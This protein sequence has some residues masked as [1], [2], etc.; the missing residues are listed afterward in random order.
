[1]RLPA[2]CFSPDPR[3]HLGRQHLSDGRLRVTQQKAGTSLSIPVHPELKKK[4][5]DAAEVGTLNFLNTSQGVTLYGRR[6]RQLFPRGLQR[7]GPPE[8]AAV[9]DRLFR[10]CHIDRDTQRWYDNV[11]CRYEASVSGQDKVHMQGLCPLVRLAERRCR[12]M[13]HEVA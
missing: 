2:H 1:M 13:L 4:V 11:R 10:E 9:P 7:G 5:L 6:L 8:G 3:P 12:P